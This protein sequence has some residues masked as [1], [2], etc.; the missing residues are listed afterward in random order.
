MLDL[1]G[2]LPCHLYNADGSPIRDASCLA[3]VQV[4]ARTRLIVDYEIRA[5][6]K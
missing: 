6:S 5:N 2:R 1:A 4:D 3:S